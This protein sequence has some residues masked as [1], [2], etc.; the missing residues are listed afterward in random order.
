M[1]VDYITILLALEFDFYKIKD[2][3]GRIFIVLLIIEFLYNYLKFEKF[4]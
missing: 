2:K 4:N 3:L 1:I